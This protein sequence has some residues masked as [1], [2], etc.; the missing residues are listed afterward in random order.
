MATKRV[1][2]V[3]H[4][5]KSVQV[6]TVPEAV[7]EE[8]EERVPYEPIPGYDVLQKRLNWLERTVTLPNVLIAVFLVLS[9]ASLVS[10]LL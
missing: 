7:V 4:V 2:P 3:K 1:K 5:V 10:F 8:V 6:N 9:V